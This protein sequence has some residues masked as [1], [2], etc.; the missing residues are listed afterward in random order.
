MLKLFLFVTT[1][2]VFGTLFW[3]YRHDIRTVSEK[4]EREYGLRQ[5]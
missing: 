5:D 4:L 1:T 2:V 3:K